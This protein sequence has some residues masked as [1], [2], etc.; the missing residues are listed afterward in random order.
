[1]REEKKINIWAYL[2]ILLPSRNLSPDDPVLWTLSLPARSTRLILLTFSPVTWRERNSLINVHMFLLCVIF[3]CKLHAIFIHMY[4]MLVD[5]EKEVNF[6]LV[7]KECLNMFSLCTVGGLLYL[8]QCC[9]H[10]CYVILI[11]LLTNS[12]CFYTLFWFNSNWGL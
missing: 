5:N 10:L 1:M 2:L 12:A 11:Q 7:T 3:L 4:I 9:Y 6:L 8:V